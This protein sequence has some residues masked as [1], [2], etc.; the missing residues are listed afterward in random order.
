M[1]K[2]NNSYPKRL[3]AISFP[4]IWLFCC[5]INLVNNYSQ[6]FNI[7]RFVLF[8]SKCR[9]SLNSFV[10]CQIPTLQNCFFP[11]K[12]SPFLVMCVVLVLNTTIA[13]KLVVWHQGECNKHILPL[14][15]RK[16]RKKLLALIS[17]VNDW[18]MNS[19][20]NCI[21]TTDKVNEYRYQSKTS[22]YQQQIDNCAQTHAPVMQ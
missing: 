8:L 14:N 16:W 19:D 22:R 10:E 15:D 1:R 21:P 3:H 11:A 5:Q 17:K 2:I 20:N 18:K 7:F 9:C 4:V 12:R 6:I 13:L